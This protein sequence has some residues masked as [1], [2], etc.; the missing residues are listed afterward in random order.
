MH[1]EEVTLFACRTQIF[2]FTMFQQL[3]SRISEAEKL[4]EKLQQ[5]VA[6]HRVT[7]NKNEGRLLRLQVLENTL[8]VFVMSFAQEERD[9]LLKRLDRYKQGGG[10][11]DEVL[12]EEL[13]DYKVSLTKL[14]INILTQLSE[15]SLLFSVQRETERHHYSSLLS[16]VLL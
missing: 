4:A 12:L 13:K 11:A 5:E 9:Q 3:R 6:Q 16:C 14:E 15:K 2:V 7:Y 1:R 10:R 8:V